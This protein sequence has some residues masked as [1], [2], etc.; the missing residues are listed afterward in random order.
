MV[1][2]SDNFWDVDL[3]HGDELGQLSK[4]VQKTDLSCELGTDEG[5]KQC[6]EC[7][8]VPC[9]VDNHQ[10]TQVFP[11]PPIQSVITLAYPAQRW[12][13]RPTCASTQVNQQIIF[14]YQQLQSSHYVPEQVFHDIG[15]VGDAASG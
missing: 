3:I 12:N 6:Q 4:A 1:Q 15:V 11:E 10:S 14:S 5:P 7:L 13:L 8:H 2:L 9:S